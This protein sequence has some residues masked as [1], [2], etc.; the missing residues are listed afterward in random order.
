MATPTRASVA[1]DRDIVRRIL[2]HIDA[3]TTDE[4]VQLAI[5]MLL[6]P[7]QELKGNLALVEPIPDKEGLVRVQSTDTRPSSP[8]EGPAPP[9][10]DGPRGESSTTSVLSSED[11]VLLAER[12]WK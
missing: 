3:G 8:I 1:D 11:K 9:G 4:G 5:Q 2:T 6:E 7:E 10:G 12:W